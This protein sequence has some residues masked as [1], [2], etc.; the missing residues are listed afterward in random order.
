MTADRQRPIGGQEQEG[1]RPAAPQR[2]QCHARSGSIE[3]GQPA[4]LG[5]AT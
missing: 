2:T 4:T 1:E 3:Q 5:R